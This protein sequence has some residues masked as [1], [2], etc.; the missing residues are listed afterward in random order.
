MSDK[1]IE[2]GEK[3]SLIGVAYGRVNAQEIG[4]R[5]A[6]V[7]KLAQPCT[8]NVPPGTK[9]VTVGF[10]TVDMFFGKGEERVGKKLKSVYFEITNED[11][12]D[13]DQGEFRCD[14]FAFLESEDEGS[15]W[16]PFFIF[17]VLC[18]G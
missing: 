1:F 16:T 4:K 3:L 9:M 12:S 13:L 18:F 7:G 10:R 11:Y 2:F 17:H 6:I 15:K 14:V 8:I 5:T